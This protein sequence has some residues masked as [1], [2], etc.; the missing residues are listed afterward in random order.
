VGSVIGALIVQSLTTTI[1]A[2][3][4]PPEVTMVVKALVVV[5]IYLVQSQATRR[6]ARTSAT[7]PVTLK[8]KETHV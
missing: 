1:Y 3:G 4:V 6:K 2:I 5:A 8:S 7:M